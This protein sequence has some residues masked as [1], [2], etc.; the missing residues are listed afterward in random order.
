MYSTKRLGE[1]LEALYKTVQLSLPG[2][3][4]P[5]AMLDE[6]V[7]HR[8]ALAVGTVPFGQ[9]APAAEPC[10]VAVRWLAVHR[11]QE[12]QSADLSV[13]TVQRSS[14]QTHRIPPY[15]NIKRV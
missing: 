13:S 8:L 2:S 5:V 14:L 1:R 7:F 4:G 10:S 11:K 12:A 9:A 15:Q 6:A 3:P